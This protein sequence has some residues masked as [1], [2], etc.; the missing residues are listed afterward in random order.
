MH[1]G[2]DVPIFG[3]CLCGAIRYRATT[4]PMGGSFCHCERSP[5]RVPGAF[6][7]QV[8]SSCDLI[9]NSLRESQAITGRLPSRDVDSVLVAVHRWFLS[10]TALQKFGYRLVPLT[11]LKTGH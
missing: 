8:F 11:I 3:G 7:R 4:P 6:F 10:M 9:S 1:A 5:G 2:P